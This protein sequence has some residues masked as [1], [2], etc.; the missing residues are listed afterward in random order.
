MKIKFLEHKHGGKII[1]LN[2][3]E[4]A[5]S[6]THRREA[7]WQFIGRVEWNDGSVSEAAHI[8]PC[9]LVYDSDDE[10]ATK[11]LFFV[12]DLLNKY[13]DRNGRWDNNVWKPE[14]KRG[15]EDIG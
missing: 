5:T 13:L 2:A 1:E 3:I 14:F 7:Y 8:A 9:T 15:R 4:H 11:E 10:E 6:T 12:S